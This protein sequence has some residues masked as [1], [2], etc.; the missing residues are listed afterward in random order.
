MGHLVGNQGHT[1]LLA[2]MNGTRLKVNMR[3]QQVVALDFDNAPVISP[4]QKAEGENYQSMND[5][6]AN[7]FIQKYAAFAYKTFSYTEEWQKFRVV[8][9]LDRILYTNDA[10]DQ[11][12]KY[13]M[14]TFPNADPNTKDSSR[15]FYGGQGMVEINYNNVLPVDTFQLNAAAVNNSKVVRPRQQLQSKKRSITRHKVPTY[16]LIRQGAYEE[17]AIRWKK[18]GNKTVA[19]KISA[20]TYFKTLPIDELL[21]IADNPFRDLFK[22]DRKPS[23]S[24]WNPPN[25]DTWLY[26][27][28]NSPGKNGKQISYNIIQVIQKLLSPKGSGDA[29]YDLA[30]QF[31]IERTGITIEVSAEIEKLRMQAD[32]FKEFLLSDTLK[33]TNPEIYQLFCR[34]KY[35]P[36]IN[37]IIDIVKMNLYD[38]HGTIRCLTHLSVANFA[39][40]LN[41]SKQK[42]SKILNLMVIT[43]ILVKLDEGQ[44]PDPLFEVINRTQQQYFDGTGAW[45]DR[46]NP[47]QYRSNVHELYNIMDNFTAIE[48]KC[49]KLIEKKFTQKGFSKE[50]VLR[51]FG[52]EE[53]NR[54][55]PQDKD[56]AISP[57]SNEFTSDIH[58]IA[59][60]QIQANGYVIVNDLK[61]E[62]Q[63]IWKSKGYIE[64]KYQQSVEEMLE[65]YGLKKIRLTK[66]LKERFG[67]TTLLPQASPTILIKDN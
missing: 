60:E 28:F 1:M 26:T 5:T 51:I 62:M 39:I 48:A 35:V 45:H 66:E 54:V 11:A 23:C 64:Y 7:E 43:E 20:I 22:S 42:I 44:I 67:I 21:G 55:F 6:L 47:R 2:I 16:K 31:L 13:L 24:I 19:D 18:Y 59:F 32:Q 49:I 8:F 36:Y 15:L 57:M 58:R 56:R 4:K 34:F 63:K 41:C 17:V 33:Y 50:W 29:P 65:I 40:R 52:E 46:D 14:E 61:A 3:E 10:V 38:D 27:K 30:V 37:A 9:I 12:Y 53:A 25:S